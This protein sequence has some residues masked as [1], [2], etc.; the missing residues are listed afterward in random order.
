MKLISHFPKPALLVLE[1]IAFGL[2]LTWLILSQK[3]VSVP[4]FEATSTVGLTSTFIPS[5]SVTTIPSTETP[6]PTQGANAPETGITVGYWDPKLYHPIFQNWVE[7]YP[8]FSPGPFTDQRLTFN[9]NADGHQELTS[10]YCEPADPTIVLLDATRRCLMIKYSDESQELTAQALS[11]CAKSCLQDLQQVSIQGSTGYLGWAES[12]AGGNWTELHWRKD[13]VTISMTLSG[14]WPQPDRANPHRLDEMLLWTAES[15]APANQPVAPPF[16][17][18]DWILAYGPKSNLNLGVPKIWQVKGNTYRGTDGFLKI[19]DYTGPGV[20]L[21]EACEAEANRSA[22]AYGNKPFI[23]TLRFDANGDLYGY[24]PCLI[25]PERKL[26]PDAQAT[27]LVPDPNSTDILK[28]RA[29][30][31]DSFHAMMVA[32]TIN[33]QL[34]DKGIFKRST[35]ILPF[36]TPGPN[37]L[38][39]NA[40]METAS[41]P[42]LGVE[43]YPVID[44]N[45]DAPGHLEFRDLVPPEVLEKRKELRK[46]TDVNPIAPIQ[47]GGHT[48]SV[49]E[50]GDNYMT[51]SAQ[52]SKDGVPMYTYLMLQH[53]AVTPIFRL[54]EYRGKWALE[55]NGMLVVDGQIMNAAWGY[56]EIFHWQELNGKVFFF[57]VK[58]GKAGIRYGDQELP[59]LYD[60]VFHHYCC[61]PAAFNVAGNDQMVWFYALKGGIWYYAEAFVQ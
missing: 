28:I 13:G 32:S 12:G 57:F 43:A 25:L 49:A 34:P 8:A 5:P 4:A 22:Q 19:E 18:S 61:E 3:P 60:Q 35:S 40:K 48:Y 58:D 23:Y 46:R 59:G 51:M 44:A 9:E 50:T 45:L 42:G 37:Q 16:L 39:P 15:L 55:V 52:V 20:Q 36:A 27:I 30:R 29:I 14:D 33:Y 7:S 26:G 53:A 41:M 47:I 56:Q 10:Y 21:D 1:L 17:P 54:G 38:S 24:G 11:N 6:H 2:M 31:T